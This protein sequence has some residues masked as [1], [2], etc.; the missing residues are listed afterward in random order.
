MK[1]TIRKMGNSQGV[2][3]PKAILAQLGLENEVEMEIVNDTLVLRRPRQAPR[4]GW[5]EASR[6]IAAD[7]DDTLVLGELPNA[8][9]AE[10]KW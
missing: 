6:Q 3:I 9:D 7:G 10:L 1:A 4:Q 2:L 5:A 8:D